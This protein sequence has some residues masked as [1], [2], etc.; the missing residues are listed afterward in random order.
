[1]IGNSTDVNGT[2]DVVE[3]RPEGTW[4]WRKGPVETA[5]AVYLNGERWTRLCYLPQAVATALRLLED[6]RQAGV[7]RELHVAVQS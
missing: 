2:R 3:V 1:M 6:A 4:R 5:W 7:E